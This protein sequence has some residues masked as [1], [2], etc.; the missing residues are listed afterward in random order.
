MIIRPSNGFLSVLGSFQVHFA[1]ILAMLGTVNVPKDE[2]GNMDR[3]YLQIYTNVWIMHIVVAVVIVL[4]NFN[5]ATLGASKYT[6][7]TLA[8]ILYIAVL[9][10]LSVDFVFEKEEKQAD[11]L[12]SAAEGPISKKVKLTKE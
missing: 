12:E 2:K 8:A 4:N 9:I 7:N 6:I 11:S 3:D 1:L 5:G 10:Q